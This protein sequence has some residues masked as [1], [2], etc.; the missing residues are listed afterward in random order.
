MAHPVSPSARIARLQ[1]AKAR[2]DKFS[3]RQKLT[4]VPMAELIGVSWPVLRAWCDDI[5]ALT[6]K[7]AFVRGGNG[8]E[9]S[10]MPKR[11]VA[12]LIEHFERIQAR[13]VRKATRQRKMSVGDI[14]DDAADGLSLDELGKMVRLNREVREE[15]ERQGQLVDV[16]RVR[17][18][19]TTMAGEIQ[20]AALR[21]AQEQDP[22]GFW[23]PKI[24]ESFE[25][26]V[27][28]ILLRIERSAQVCLV[29]LNGSPAKPG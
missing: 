6:E 26:A 7:A 19:V 4:S 28:A 3:Q 14:L 15:R 27:Q 20:Q 8:I 22:N 29:S 5:P 1:L 16:S 21:A 2:A 24:R 18:A 11:M 17:V 25:D 9:W 12:V 10:F 23:E 13:G